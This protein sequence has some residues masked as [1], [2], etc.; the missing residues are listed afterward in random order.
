MNICY[1]NYAE[2]KDFSAVEVNFKLTDIKIFIAIEG[3]VHIYGIILPF[4]NKKAV[5]YFKGE[6]YGKQS[7]AYRNYS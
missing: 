2:T 1:N 7:S 3:K 6:F 4:C 5:F